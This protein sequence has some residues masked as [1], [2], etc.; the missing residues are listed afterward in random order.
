MYINIFYVRC[1]GQSLKKISYGV[2]STE[3]DA[4]LQQNI[5]GQ[6]VYICIHANMHSDKKSCHEDLKHLDAICKSDEF[7]CLKNIFLDFIDWHH[8]D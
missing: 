4:S 5:R 2:F 3:S 7:V 6:Y 8:C 1:G